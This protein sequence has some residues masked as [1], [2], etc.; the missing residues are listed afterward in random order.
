MS[1]IFLSILMKLPSVVVRV[2]CYVTALEALHDKG[3]K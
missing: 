3:I 2:G 1:M